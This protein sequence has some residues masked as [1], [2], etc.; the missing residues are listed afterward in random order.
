MSKLL[1][2]PFLLVC[3]VIR[4]SGNDK[5][6][7]VLTSVNAEGIEKVRTSA[8]GRVL[9]MNFW[10]TWCKPCM[11]EFPDLVKLQQTYTEKGVDVV[12]ISIDDDDAKTKRKVI[13]FLKK[14]NVSSQTYIKRRGNDEAFI[15]AVN[16]QWSGALP[17]TLVYK[18]NGELAALKSEE[19]N[20]AELQ[21]LI[22]PLLK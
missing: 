8:K 20:Y 22:T 5:P 1:L 4:A 6:S 17:T 14:M 12:F 3:I 10:A 2:A 11:Q 7:P 21:R 18:R 15:N 19:L 13:S 9:V 16:P